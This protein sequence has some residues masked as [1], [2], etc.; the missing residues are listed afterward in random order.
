MTDSSFIAAVFNS[1][2][3]D[4]CLEEIHEPVLRD[5]EVL[6]RLS[7]TGI[8]HTDVTVRE[9]SVDLPRPFILGH[10]G[11]G[12]VERVGST[13]TSVVPHDPVVISFHFCGTCSNCRNGLPAYCHSFHR[14]NFTGRRLDGS[15]ALNSSHGEVSGHFFGQSSFATYSVANERNVVK[16]RQDAPLELLGPLGCGIQTGAGTVMNVLQPKPGESILIIGAGSVGLSAVM[17]A[18]IEGCSPIIVVEPNAARRKL[19]VEVGA[20]H[21]IDPATNAS[22][23][24]RIRAITAG[25]V[26]A[27]IDTSGVTK[28]IQQALETLGLCGKLAIVTKAKDDSALPVDLGALLK[29]GIMIR[30]VIQGDSLPQEFIPKLVDLIMEGRFPLEKLV[31]FYAFDEINTALADQ[32]NGVTVK[33]IIRF[34]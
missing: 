9:G 32:K 13:V 25:S 19:A 3:E 2:N 18:M 14:A 26:D 21:V 30:G 31:R 22:I 15:T 4:A 5:D 34:S 7:A 17:A 11:A 20:N 6:V 23:E 8:C 24:D 10:E 1:D 33:P 27:A 29:R 12:I 28:V 16:V